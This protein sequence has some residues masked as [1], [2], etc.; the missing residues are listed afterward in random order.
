MT[1]LLQK[2]YVRLPGS[3][4]NINISQKITSPMSH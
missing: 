1:L 4:I 3:G 2:Q